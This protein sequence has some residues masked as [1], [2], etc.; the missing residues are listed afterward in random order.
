MF[1]YGE[2]VDVVFLATSNNLLDFVPDTSVGLTGC[3]GQGPNVVC[4]DI[5]SLTDVWCSS[6]GGWIRDM[7]SDC[8]AL[9]MLRHDEI[10]L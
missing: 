6:A 8:S 7:A 4:G 10:A 9:T 3:V 2:D 5:E 1:L